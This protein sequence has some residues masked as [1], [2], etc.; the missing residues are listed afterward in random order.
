MSTMEIDRL[1]AFHA[2]IPLLA[3]MLAS[4]SDDIGSLT[5]QDKFMIKRAVELVLGLAK[6]IRE[7]E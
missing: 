1:Q 4:E 2:A 5:E 6:M 3:G 7:W